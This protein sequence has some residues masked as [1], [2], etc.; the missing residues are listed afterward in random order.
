[1]SGEHAL[2]V[3]AGR[4]F[5]FGKNWESFLQSVNNDR[6]AEAER[7][8]G[9]ML[10][11]S[12]LTGKTFLDIG[13]GSGLLSLA[14]RRLGA[15]VRSFDYDPNSVGCTGELKRRYFPLDGGWIVENGSV[16]DWSYLAALGQFD[17]VY[18]WGVLHHTGQMWTALD[19]A[20]SLVAPGG[21]L[22][23]AIYNDQE[24]IS[25]RWT[26]VK[27]TY[28]QSKLMR[29]PLLLGSFL[30]LY[31]RPLLKDFL[32]LRPFHTLRSYGRDGETARGM[33][34]WSDLVDW[35]GGYPFEVAKPEKIFD[36]FRERG[37]ELT[38]LTTT[39]TLGCNEFV[40]EKKT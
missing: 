14:A 3:S 16:L 4:R 21:R 22:F 33:S 7:S 18:S 23:I 28:N 13:S 2:E 24:A 8:L 38:R 20:A 37:F 40:F 25:R 11:V 34:W 5:G 19:H 15:Q 29:G 17:V 27:R 39:N 35:V 30:H 1:M 31:G 10:G 26:W 36:F 32:L 6:I 9:R 12:S